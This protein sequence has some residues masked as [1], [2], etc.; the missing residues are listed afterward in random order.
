VPRSDSFPALR[1]FV[2]GV[3]AAYGVGPEDLE[4]LIQESFLK[5]PVVLLTRPDDNF[6]LKVR[7]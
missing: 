7:N 5:K 2:A 6:G 3:G 4:D 1:P